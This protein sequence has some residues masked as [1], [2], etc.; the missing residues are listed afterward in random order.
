MQLSVA[1]T[2]AAKSGTSAAQLASALVDWSEAPAVI[3]GAVV[4]T[5]WT[6]AVHVAVLPE[7]SVAVSVTV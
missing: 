6:V 2:P 4:S 7:A 1:V 5:T 3:T